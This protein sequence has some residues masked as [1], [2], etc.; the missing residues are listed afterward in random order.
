MPTHTAKRGSDALSRGCCRQY[1][2][3]HCRGNEL[4]LGVHLISEGVCHFKT[5]S[6]AVVQHDARLFRSMNRRHVAQEEEVANQSSSGRREEHRC[7]AAPCPAGQTALAQSWGRLVT[8]ACALAKRVA[9]LRHHV[10]VSGTTARSACYSRPQRPHPIADPPPSSV[11]TFPLLPFPL[12]RR[13][14]PVICAGTVRRG[15]STRRRYGPVQEEG[16]T[17]ATAAP[18]G[19]AATQ[20]GRYVTGACCG[21]CSGW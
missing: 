4:D 18:I 7:M 21:C 9:R 14:S 3:G 17:A 8:C 6:N 20:H 2:T 16:A 10:V 11:V 15:R 1:L 5:T 12:S 19:A 13:R